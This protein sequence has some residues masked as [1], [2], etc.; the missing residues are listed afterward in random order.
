MQTAVLRQLCKLLSFAVG[1]RR[2]LL[3]YDVFPMFQRH[4]HEGRMA[5][6]RCDDEHD[7]HLRLQ[8]LSWIRDQLDAGTTSLK[9]LPSF[10]APG[11]HRSQPRQT[12]RK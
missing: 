8:N 4:L 2:R 11:A 10:L 7:I 12:A 1:R 3:Y 5:C 9:V 6:R